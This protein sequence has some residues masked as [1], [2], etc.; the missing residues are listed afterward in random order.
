MKTVEL[1]TAYHWNCEECGADNFDLG[2][3]VEMTEEQREQ[4]FREYESLEIWEEL[5]EDWQLFE[6]A[7]ISTTVKCKDC[8]T[9][10]LTMDERLID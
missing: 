9:E 1:K 6:L 3:K 2:Q 4:C 8:G 5:P 7:E 10:F